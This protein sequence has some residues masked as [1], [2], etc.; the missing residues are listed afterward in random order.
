METTTNPS[1]HSEVLAAI[2]SALDH[3]DDAMALFSTADRVR[4]LFDQLRD[5]D[6]IL[7][8]VERNLRHDELEHRP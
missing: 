6:M 7:C 2:R 1:E 5:A 8:D 3:L 4:D